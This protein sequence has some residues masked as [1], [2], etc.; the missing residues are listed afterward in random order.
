MTVKVA[1]VLESV[2][3][4]PDPLFPRK[5]KRD[6]VLDG[7][8]LPEGAHLHVCIGAANRDP[9]RWENPEKF[10]AARVVWRCCL[11]RRSIP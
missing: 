11:A 9:A 6:T 7:V 3:W 1:A 10:D 2:R 4:L 8:D 5:V